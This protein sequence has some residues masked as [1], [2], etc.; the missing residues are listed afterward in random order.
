MGHLKNATGDRSTRFLSF[1][2]KLE[3]GSV[4]FF[5][6]VKCENPEKYF[7]VRREPTT[8]STHI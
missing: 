5:E 8:N 3:F 4:G 1:W 2:I 6:R 7:G